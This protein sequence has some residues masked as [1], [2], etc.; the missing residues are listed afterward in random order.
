MK[1]NDQTVSLFSF[2][3]L[4]IYFLYT[5]QT[6]HHRIEDTKAKYNTRGISD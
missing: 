3:I 5:D 6:A 4:F 2:F 1:Q